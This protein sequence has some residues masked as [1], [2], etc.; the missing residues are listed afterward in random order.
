MCPREFGKLRRG[1]TLGT[2][3]T[4]CAT[5]RRLGIDTIHTS[6]KNCNRNVGVAQN[7]TQS[8]V[9]T[10]TPQ[11]SQKSWLGNFFD[12]F[13]S[14]VKS[15]TEVKPFTGMDFMKHKLADGSFKFDES[16]YTEVKQEANKLKVDPK[17][18][19][20]VMVW[21]IMTDSKEIKYKLVLRNLEKWLTS[22]YKETMAIDDLKDKIRETISQ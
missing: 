21:I 2:L 12:R 13:K 19:F 14:K 15:S 16:E 6:L 8:D 18:Y 1:A 10:P 20:N 3:E 5:V 11:Q 22:N 17:I 7:I 4:Q 9:V